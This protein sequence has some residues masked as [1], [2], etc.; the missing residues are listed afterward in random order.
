[1]LNVPETVK[2][3]FKADGVRKNFRV[4]FPNGELPDI[5]NDNIV[6][7]S[8]KFTESICSQD[9]FKFGLAEASVL[10]FETVGVANMY[11]MTIEA[12]IEIDLS[13]LSAA[14]IAEIAAGSWDGVY[15][16]ESATDIGFPFFRVPYGLFR[17]ESCPRD[18]QVMTHRKVTAYTPSMQTILRKK[19]EYE[20]GKS[21]FWFNMQFPAG[22]IDAF[23]WAAAKLGNSYPQF[24]EDYYTKSLLFSSANMSTVNYDLVTPSGSTWRLYVT[25][26]L[27]RTSFQSYRPAIDELW[28]INLG[29]FD[30]SGAYNY[31]Q[32]AIAAHG[33]QID[34]ISNPVGYFSQWVQARTYMPQSGGLHD[35]NGFPQSS[36][37]YRKDQIAAYPYVYNALTKTDAYVDLYFPIYAKIELK[38]SGTTRSSFESTATEYPTVYK[39]IPKSTYPEIIAAINPTT[40]KEFPTDS[41]ETTPGYLYDP[42]ESYPGMLESFFEILGTIVKQARNGNAVLLTL[43]NISPEAVLPGNYSGFWW[44]EYDVDPIGLVSVTYKDE[45]VEGLPAGISVGSGLSQYDMTD[46]D[47]LKNLFSATLEDVVTIIDTY[48]VPNIGALDYTPI[49]LSMKGLPYLEAGDYL[50]VTGEDGVTANSFAMRQ[51]INGVH[52]LEA[53]IES[54]SG[55][56][57]ESGESV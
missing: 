13:S 44:D 34:K 56:I 57:I 43:D 3:L 17:V 35:Q 25:M 23:T 41:G 37:C 26:T 19:S 22:K 29:N 20:T 27:M 40:T 32:E 49:D 48:F 2:A 31:I 33:S 45:N 52:V 50:A 47:L 4:Q 18:H 21:A 24:L 11:G 8:V 7:E 30:Y 42:T 6:Q 55:D 15:V 28:Q 54:T 51:T 10:E 36:F 46:N 53:H 9:V 14:E 16:S 39:Y 5:T 1:M 12:G 38:E